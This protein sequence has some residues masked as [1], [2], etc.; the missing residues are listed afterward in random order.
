MDQPKLEII[1]NSARQSSFS[2]KAQLLAHAAAGTDASERKRAAQEFASFLYLE[3]LKAMRATLPKDGLFENDSLSM[4]LYSSIFDAEIARTLAKRDTEGFAKTVERALEKILPK[5]RAEAT[6]QLPVVGS[7]SSAFGFRADPITGKKS[8]HTG[9]DIA[10]PAGAEI[11]AAVAGTVVFS[12]TA[13]GYG[14][15]VEIDHGA[16]IVTRYAHT[17][18]NLV[19]PGQKIRTGETIAIAGRT[20]R[21][22]GVHLHFEVRQ[23][24]KPLNPAPWLSISGPGAKLDTQA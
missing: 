19:A 13:S 22:T 5:R 3:V 16:G 18:A 4:D 24:G 2:Q 20:G 15:M 11:A 9:I 10:A 21:A 17:A 14:N 8:F 6:M 12:G 1:A 23:D 7:T